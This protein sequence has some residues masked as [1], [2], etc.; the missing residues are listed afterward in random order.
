MGLS[1]ANTAGYTK[2]SVSSSGIFVGYCLG[3]L[4]NSETNI[5][6]LRRQ[7]SGLTR[8]GN[9]VGPLIFKQQ[10]A[11]EYDP[12]LIGTVVTAIAAALLVLVYRLVCIWHHK[13]RDRKGTENFEHAYEDGHTDKTNKTFRYTL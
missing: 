11:P 1:I 9:V 5:Y 3:R 7:R 13:R 10:D 4:A 6:P 12:G 8:L 2:R